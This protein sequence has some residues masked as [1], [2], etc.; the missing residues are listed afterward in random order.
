MSDTLKF[1][2]E[3]ILKLIFAFAGISII[4]GSMQLGV[5]SLKDPGPG[6][7][8]LI[9]GSLIVLESLLLLGKRELQQTKK[10]KYNIKKMLFIITIFISWIVLMPLFGHIGITFLST[11]FFSKAMGLEGWKKPLLL[12]FGISCFCYLLFDIYLYTDLP[13][14]FFPLKWIL[15]I[16]NI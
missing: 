4:I 2:L 11:I 15:S 14:G 3:V 10:S 12:S 7:F 5:G 8:P 6:L 13:S 16:W 9:C 1:Q